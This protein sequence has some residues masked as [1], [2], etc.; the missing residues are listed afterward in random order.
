[1][2]SAV[3]EDAAQAGWRVTVV[4]SARGYNRDE[5]YPNFAEH[6]GVGVHRVGGSRFNRD[7]VVGRLT[8]YIT[9]LVASGWKLLWLPAPDCLVVTSAPPFSLALAWFLSAVRRVR[10]VFVAEDLYPEIAVASGILRPGSVTARLAG[11]LFGRWLC[12]AAAIIVLGEHMKGRLLASH[13][14]LDPARVV[15]ID[16]WHDGKRLFPLTPGAGGPMC[17]QYSGNFGEGH[18]FVTLVNALEQVK[19]DAQLRFQFVGG[20]RRRP[21]LEA[22]VKTRGLANCSFHDYVPEADLN[23]S[24]NAADVCLV[25]VARGFEGLLVPS[26]IYGI[27][28][29]G[30]PVLYYGAP[31]G[32]VPALV[33]RHDLGWVIEQGDVAGLVRA[34]REAAGDSQLRT[35]FG[36]NARRAFEAHYDRPLATARYLRVF[37]DAVVNGH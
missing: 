5:I 15:P 26:K 2:I 19:A 16:N 4:T 13:P 8:N 11:W 37:E 20:G 6:S 29:V 12:R 25:T 23:A 18:D 31:E 36:A 14:R 28:A 24:L 32:D 30:K 10:F 7:S 17:V 34:L 3:A 35:R 9:F 1:M 22:E 27:M 21:W 33:R